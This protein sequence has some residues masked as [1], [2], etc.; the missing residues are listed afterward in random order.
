[1][2]KFKVVIF[3]DEGGWVLINPSKSEYSQYTHVLDPDLSEVA[4]MPPE[5]WAL[6]DGKVVPRVEGK[7][8]VS[9]SLRNRVMVIGGIAALAAAVLALI[10]YS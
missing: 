4:G 6:R 8:V 5:F 1:V 2:K 10:L 3:T 7:P 9:H